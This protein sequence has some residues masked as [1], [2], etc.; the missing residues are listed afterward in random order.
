[1]STACESNATPLK[2]YGLT[3]LIAHHGLRLGVERALYAR[4]MLCDPWLEVPQ[5][6]HAMNRTRMRAKRT[7][8]LSILL[9]LLPVTR[10][11]MR[12]AQ[13]WSRGFPR[14]LMSHVNRVG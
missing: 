8:C 13:I 6:V 14:Y 9:V 5:P 2:N 7:K 1:M 11:P 12:I 10:A 4:E 3:D